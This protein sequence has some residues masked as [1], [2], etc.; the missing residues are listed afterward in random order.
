MPETLTEKLPLLFEEN[1]L[2]SHAGQ[3]IQDPRFAIIEL[4]ANCWDAGATQVEISYPNSTGE[5]FFIKDNGTGMTTEEFKSRWNSLSYN[6]LKHQS[7]EVE[8]PKGK[9]NRNRL[10]FGKNG[11]GRHAMFCFCN[12]YDIETNK[13]GV[14]TKAKVSMS[15]GPMPFDIEIIKVGKAKVKNGT[16]ISG[17]VWKNIYLKEQS[18]IDLIGSKFIADPEFEIVVNSTKVLMADFNKTSVLEEFEFKN[19]GKAIIRRFEGERNK[20]TQQQGVAWWVRRRLVGVPSWDG[21]NG[22]LIDGRNPIAKK[23]VYV[24]EVDFLKQHVKPDWS[25]FYIT[26]EINQVRLE[27]LDFINN[28]LLS[29]LS[30]TR[31]E[32]KSEAFQSNAQHL[33]KLPKFIQSEISEVIDDLQKE[34]PTFG[35]NELETTVKVL[36]IME[37]SRSGYE[38]L[39]KLSKFNHND[40]DALNN[41]LTEWSIT[42]IKKVVSVLNWRLELVK[43]LERLVDNS[44]TDELHD[45]QPLF[46]R[47]LWIFGPEFETLSF[48]S[49]RTLSSIIKLYFTERVLEKPNRRPDFVI[50]PDASIGAYSIEAFNEDHEIEGIGAVVI[51]EL[52]KGGFDIDDKEKDQAMYYA[53]EI[54]KSGKVGRTT[55]ITCYVLGSTIDVNAE[56]KNFDGSITII[57]MRYSTLISKAKARLFGLIEE[58]EK[59][60]DLNKINEISDGPVELFA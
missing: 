46:E 51:V 22:R 13:E 41:V 5:T 55:K 2:I 24:I 18:V 17:T 49:N 59:Y 60:K 43:E 16:F 42:D 57:P 8:F 30:E 14:C 11:V 4:I 52:K 37:K 10:P 19:L 7:K 23:Y 48:M 58:L 6:R 32:R 40:I 12:E 44:T 38:L 36:A 39:E 34:C 15:K 20:T 33:R 21:I 28:D 50:L 25:G 45:L 56:T 29:L 9:K 54:R 53:R 31:K 27:L 26:P 3:I 1:F 47:G 35:M